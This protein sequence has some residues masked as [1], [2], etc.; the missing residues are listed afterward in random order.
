MTT[1]PRTEPKFTNRTVAKVWRQLF[2]D[3]NYGDESD[4]TKE[5]IFGMMVWI[6]EEFQGR[7]PNG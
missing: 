1:E 2:Q 7:K 3:W 5:Y 6:E 4:E